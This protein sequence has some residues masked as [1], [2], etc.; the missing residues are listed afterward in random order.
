MIA[1]LYALP[2]RSPE[3]TKWK[4][5]LFP[6]QPPPTCSSLFSTPKL[7]VPHKP[8]HCTTFHTEFKTSIAEREKLRAQPFILS[9]P[10]I[11]SK[12][13]HWRTW[14]HKK[15]KAIK[16]E[17]T[18]NV[19]KNIRTRVKYQPFC[20]FKLKT[21][22]FRLRIVLASPLLDFFQSFFSRRIFAAFFFSSLAEQ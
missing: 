10:P 19:T 12:G 2:R 14:D 20:K 15:I 16:T 9:C 6:Q 21:L 22:Y 3:L 8:S 4:K 1:S 11:R 17:N 13:R 18:R 7:S 5:V